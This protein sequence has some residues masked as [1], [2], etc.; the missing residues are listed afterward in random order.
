MGFTVQFKSNHVAFYAYTC[1]WNDSYL[2]YAENAPDIVSLSY[3]QYN[4]TFLAFS[5]YQKAF[6]DDVYFSKVSATLHIL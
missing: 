1:A 6:Y 3:T 2:P 5:W 4:K